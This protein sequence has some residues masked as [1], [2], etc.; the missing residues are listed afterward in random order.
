[1]FGHAVGRLCQLAVHAVDTIGGLLQA[2]NESIR[3]QAAKAILDS[4]MRFHRLLDTDRRLDA[5][6]GDELAE[7]DP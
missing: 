4:G 6:P 1:M 7:I 3:L 5:L 2:N